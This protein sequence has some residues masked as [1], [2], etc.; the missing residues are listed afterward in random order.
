MNPLENGHIYTYVEY[1][2]YIILHTEKGIKFKSVQYVRNSDTC[3]RYD[4]ILATQNNNIVLQP[5]LKMHGI[6]TQHNAE[7]L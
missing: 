2:T 7:H 6:V 4:F 5:E 3:N 1:P